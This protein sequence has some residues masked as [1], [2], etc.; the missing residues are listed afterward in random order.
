MGG[1]QQRGGKLLSL[2]VLLRHHRSDLRAALLRNYQVDLRAA[3][4]EKNLQ[5]LADLTLAIPPGDPLWIAYGG[6]LAWSM[7]AHLIA[8]AIDQLRIANW[9]RTQDGQRGI[10]RPEPLTPPPL[11]R[12]RDRKSQAL[13]SQARAFLKRQRQRSAIIP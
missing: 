7:E 3:L 11:A 13:E 10:N 12:D 5:D 4:A 9:Q 1:G 6:P 8:A 2:A